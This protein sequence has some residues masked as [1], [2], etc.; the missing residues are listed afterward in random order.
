[1]F[2]NN[3]GDLHACRTKS[4][5]KKHENLYVDNKFSHIKVPNKGEN[6]LNYKAD[7]KSTQ[8]RQIKYTYSEYF[9]K[10]VKYCE[11]NPNYNHI[12]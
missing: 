4:I 2:S 1:M 6:I 12:K 3:H 9:L 10:N 7:N 11:P 5:L 8:K